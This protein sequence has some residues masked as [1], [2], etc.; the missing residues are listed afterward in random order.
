[1]KQIFKWF[2]FLRLSSGIVFLCMLLQVYQVS[3]HPA[4]TYNDGAYMTASV[5][6]SGT[7]ATVSGSVGRNY[8]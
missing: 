4:P 7:T 8:R 5:S 6:V 1:M 3:A 2:N